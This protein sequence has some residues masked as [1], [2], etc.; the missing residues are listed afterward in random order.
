MSSAWWRRPP[1]PPGA[2]G[3]FLRARYADKRCRRGPGRR[4][5][6]VELVKAL[7]FR[8]ITTCT[9]PPAGTSVTAHT[10]AA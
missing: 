9:S 7:R 10:S 5:Y 1:R 6:A 8:P 4:R 2:A 3:V